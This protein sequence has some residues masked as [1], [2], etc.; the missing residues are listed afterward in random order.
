[1]TRL[2]W[3]LLAGSAAAGGMLVVAPA[4]AQAA[5]DAQPGQAAPPTSI[6][7]GE[8]AATGDGQTDGTADIVVTGVR[9]SLNSAIAKKRDAT[10][11]VDSIV[12][13]DI[14]K[15]PDNNVAEALQRITGVQ[16]SRNQGEGSGIAIRGLSQVQTL[17]NGRNLFTTS[18]RGV[19]LADI[20][21]ELL[22]GIDVY[23]SSAAD[24]IEGGLGGLIDIRL[25]RPFDFRETELSV[26]ARGFRG[27]IADKVDPRISFLASDRYQT[28]I[29]EIG[30]LVSLVYQQRSFGSYRNSIGTFAPVT[31][32][33]DLN[34]N[35]VFPND[36][37]DAIEVTTDAGT[38]YATGQRRRYGVNSSLQWAPSD[39]LEFY[40][41]GLFNTTSNTEDDQLIF[42]RTGSSGIR[43]SN[44]RP[45]PPFTLVPGTN[46]FQTGTYTNARTTPSTYAQDNEYDTYQGV[47]GGKWRAGALTLTGEGGYTF[48]SG[49]DRF[50]EIGI[51]TNAPL[52]TV[53]LSG[54]FPNVTFAGVDIAN[55]AVYTF[56][57]F[58]DSGN[59]IKGGEW[60]GRLDGNLEI[61]GVL[62]S[63]KAGIRY[64]DRNAQR[65]GFNNAPTF[66]A[67][68]TLPRP[69]DVP[70]LLTLTPTDLFRNRQGLGTVQWAAPSST[71]VRQTP[72]VRA[73]FGLN[74]DGPGDDPRQFYDITERTYA[75][76]GQAV[77]GFDLAGVELDGNVGIR[78]VKT[79]TDLNGFRSAQAGGFEA[80]GQSNGYDDWLPSANLRAK[81]TP[82]LFLRAAASKVVT[83][84]T[85]AQLTPATTLN[86]LFLT[87]SGGN[88]NLAPLRADQYD[89]SLEYYPK[90]GT[91]L[92]L[93]G[94]YK[95][96]NGFVQNVSANKATTGRC[97]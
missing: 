27:D 19:A 49:T 5:A 14:G 73:L 67:N 78:Y 32:L 9:A 30:V 80:V 12:A 57:R 92:Y 76:Y 35:G 44:A 55:P 45:V 4:E 36:P 48:S 33:Y 59:R 81:L 53:D 41:D 87:G 6:P 89:L 75:A 43:Q 23:K 90:A 20:P 85:F 39:N 46:I 31:S 84:P 69:I 18:G 71:F 60:V 28:G 77:F 83:R 51:Q 10:Q 37:G 8:P 82:E 96:V 40:V 1:M 29:G 3:L 97:S 61:G 66:A 95:N 94:F 16:I 15:L 74:P 25:R 72:V 17:V 38:R 58:A 34:G 93:A 13:E 70:G 42:G 22:A 52:Y 54:G 2:G 7:N 62:K 64:A 56:D 26:T 68:N 65:A 63:L 11:I 79:D 88:P 24:Q 47:F 50:T 21:A 91:L 86:F